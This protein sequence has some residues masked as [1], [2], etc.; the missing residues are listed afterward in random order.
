MD[1]KPLM[2]MC[3]CGQLLEHDTDTCPDCLG[4]SLGLSV[5]WAASESELGMELTYSSGSQSPKD[6]DTNSI[7][8][9]GPTADMSR[10]GDVV[11][12]PECRGAFA[13]WECECGA[14]QAWRRAQACPCLVKV[15]TIL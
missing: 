6:R 5:S 3:A 14:C 4:S 2:R 8:T 10:K 7:V 12:T 13:R 1:K 15:C 9:Q 11:N